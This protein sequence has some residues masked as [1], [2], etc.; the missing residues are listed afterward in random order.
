MKTGLSQEELAR[1]ARTDRTYVNSLEQR[2]YAAGINLV[3]RLAKELGVT[4]AEF[5]RDP[6]AAPGSPCT[7]AGRRRRPTQASSFPVGLGQNAAPD[8]FHAFD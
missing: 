8:I 7:I 4:A 6:D 1:R 3:D 2:V 5:L